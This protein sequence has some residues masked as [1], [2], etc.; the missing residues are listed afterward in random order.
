VPPKPSHPLC[1]GSRGR[2]IG[3]DPI[4]GVSMTYA[5][6]QIKPE[7]STGAIVVTWDGVEV[8]DFTHRDSAEYYVERDVANRRRADQPD[9]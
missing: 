1:S 4:E 8:A 5:I 2:R 6:E 3:V 9:A 7:G